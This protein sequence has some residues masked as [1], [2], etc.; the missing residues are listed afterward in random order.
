MKNLRTLMFWAGAFAPLIH[1]LG[2]MYSYPLFA[3]MLLIALSGKYE[4]AGLYYLLL[5]KVN[6][7]AYHTPLI[8][9][10]WLGGDSPEVRAFTY[11]LGVVYLGIAALLRL[12]E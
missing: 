6:V 9:W 2:I 5:A 12:R 11:C 3:C 8:L 10:M 7:V 1:S 4:M